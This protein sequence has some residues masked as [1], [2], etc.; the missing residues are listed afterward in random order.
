MQTQSQLHSQKTSPVTER[1]SKVSIIFLW[2]L[3][4]FGGFVYVIGITILSEQFGYDYRVIQMPIIEMIILLCGS[5]IGLFLLYFLIKLS[6]HSNTHV[7]AVLLLIIL[8]G[9]LFRLILFASEPMLEDDYQRYFWDG[10]LTAQGINPYKYSPGDIKADK[11]IL[12]EITRIKEQA[13]LVLD[14]INHPQLRTIYPAVS[15]IMFS[16]AYFIE[17]FSITSWRFLLLCFDGI[18]LFLL[19]KLLL[20]FQKS[21][22]WAALYWWNPV[23]LK[24]LFNSAHMEAILIPFILGTLWLALHKRYLLSS[25]S[26][27]F[28]VGI[29]VWPILLFPLVLRPILHQPL[30]LLF[31]SV[32]AFGLIGL[33]FLP[34]ILTTL[35]QNSGFVAYA[36]Q[37]KTNSALMKFLSIFYQNLFEYFYIRNLQPN[38]VIRFTIIFITLI[39]LCFLFFKNSKTQKEWLSKIFIMCL[40]I[41]LCSPAQFPWY[42]VWV[43]PFIALFPLYSL[44]F[45]SMTIPLYY[46]AFYLMSHGNL[47]IYNNVIIWLIW[48]PVWILLVYDFTLNNKVLC[49]SDNKSIQKGSI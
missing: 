6:L 32:L 43:A 7:R 38:L 23:V 5:G 3:A 8:C 2:S 27:A 18:S 15:Q 24:E 10:A 30:K 46:S 19:I 25:V 29:K 14:R 13:G 21:P 35:D 48:I 44:L 45:L 9:C 11:I 17:P 47:Q 40:V 31:C 39:I 12:P 41:F 33:W 4:A 22:L 20:F 16:V 1:S 28:A 42:Y 36:S 26:L 34:V 49:L 37:W